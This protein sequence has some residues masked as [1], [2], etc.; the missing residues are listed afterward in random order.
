MPPSWPGSTPAPKVSRKPMPE[1]LHLLL[2][3]LSAIL[4]TLAM[5]ALV[6]WL[7]CGVMPWALQGLWPRV[8][9]LVA[10]LAGYIFC[11]NALFYLWPTTTERFLATAGDVLPTP[12]DRLE[13]DGR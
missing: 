7:R 6:T 12:A 8:G 9:A 10:F 1:Y 4:L 2:R 3:V 13:D 11:D 5:L